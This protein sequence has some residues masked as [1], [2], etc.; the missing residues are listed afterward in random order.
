MSR[1][2]VVLSRHAR[3]KHRPLLPPFNIRA[4]FPAGSFGTKD[5]ISHFMVM[6][7]GG[8]LDAIV[9]AISL[10]VLMILLVD[11]TSRARG[12]VGLGQSIILLVLLG[13][14]EGLFKDGLR[15]VE[16]KFGLEVP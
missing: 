11:R 16:F 1:N 15:L 3:N 6:V 2:M 4:T 9:L 12:G 10:E 7:S 8:D 13:T 14:V 5:F